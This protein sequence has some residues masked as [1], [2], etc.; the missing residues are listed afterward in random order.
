MCGVIVVDW[1][2][3][4]AVWAVRLLVWDGAVIWPLAE[5]VGFGWVL[6]MV[7]VVSGMLVVRVVVDVSVGG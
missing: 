5:S 7:G 6:W 2:L 1:Q 3:W 4:A